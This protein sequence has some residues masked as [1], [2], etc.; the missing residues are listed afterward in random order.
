MIKGV[1]NKEI[2]MG[3]IQQAY[4]LPHPPVIIPEIGKGK[5]A[6]ASATIEAYKLVGKKIAEL[7]PQVIILITPHGPSYGDYI[8]ITPGQ[9][10]HGRL[11]DFGAP[12]LNFKFNSDAELKKKII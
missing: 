2:A 6:D 8:Y 12:E 4:I 7:A 5:E 3:E 9:K 10:L 11:N 1:L